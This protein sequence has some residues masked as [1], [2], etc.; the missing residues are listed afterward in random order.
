MYMAAFMLVMSYFAFHFITGQAPASIGVILPSGPGVATFDKMI[1]GGF[2]DLQFDKPMA[3]TTAHGRVYIS[4]SNNA[5]IQVFDNAGNFLF[6]FG[7]K[8]R[9][10][11]EFLYPYGIAGDLNGNVYVSELYLNR[12]QVYNADGEYQ[13]DFATGLVE[14]GL[15]KS[16]ADITIVGSQMYLTDVSLNRVLV[17]N[18]ETEE[19]V[20]QIGLELDVM[21]PNGVAVDEAGNIFVVDTGRQ[22]VVVYGADGNPVRVIN[23]TPTGHGINSVL[24]NPRGIG[25]DRSGN[26]YVVSNMSH[27]VFVFDREGK[28]I[29][30]FGGQGDGNT[31]FLFPNGL[32]VDNGGRIFITDTAN[33]RVAIY[34]LR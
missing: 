3:V 25:V 16:P 13:R 27:T 33:Q 12:V 7:E 28:Q 18:L 30:S 2:G 17:I 10:A 34:R 26:I 20:R 9:N 5:R 22:R 11:G 23:G 15:I 29:H 8:G 32:H 31:Q 4:D 24:I 6:T 19:L 1:Y 14:D 21:A